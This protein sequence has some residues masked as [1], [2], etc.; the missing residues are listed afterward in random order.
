LLYRP[1]F[2]RHSAK[3]SRDF[4]V[5]CGIQPK[6]ARARLHALGHEVLVGG[7]LDRLGGDLVDEGRRDNDHAVLV[8]QDDVAREHRASPQA[9]GT[10]MSTAWCSV[11]LVG[12]LGRW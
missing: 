11:R 12:A 5:G 9:I 10:L 1:F 4:G 7:H 8:A 6:D 3:C 2:F